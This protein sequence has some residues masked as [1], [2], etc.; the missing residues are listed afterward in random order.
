LYTDNASDLQV[1]VMELF[2]RGLTKV[3]LKRT[4]LKSLTAL[5]TNRWAHLK[6]MLEKSWGFIN[7]MTTPTHY[8][9]SELMAQFENGA[10]RL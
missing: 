8:G 2:G 5:L 1:V 10:F 6:V 3:N 4:L 9:A 7:S